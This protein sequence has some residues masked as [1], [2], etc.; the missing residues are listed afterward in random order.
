MEKLPK[1]VKRRVTLYI[2][3]RLLVIVVL[4][5]LIHQRNYNNVFT[6]ILTLV[7]FMI[8]AIADRK[9][10]IKLPTALEVVIL[11]FIFAAEILGEIQGFY[12]AFKYWDLMLHTINGFLMAAIGFAMI[13]ILN[14][15]PRIHIN[16]SPAF[17]AFVAFCFSMTIGVVWEFFEFGMDTYARTDMQKDTLCQTVS[18]VDF[19]PAGVNVPVV[20]S[21]IQ[22]TVIHGTIKGEQTEL[23]IEGGY[24][25]TGLR[26]TM[27]DMLVNLIG[28][29]VFSGLGFF[30]IKNRGKGRIVPSFIPR[31]KT[32]AEIAETEKELE[33]LR[34]KR[35]KTE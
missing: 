35:G 21:D 12:L 11:L 25:D 2:V 13:D 26:D 1:G 33:E 27:E 19:N 14:Q 17:V 31:L 20:V 18:S 6:C 16:L 22:E 9:L 3:L 5:L 28:A 23:V 4:I 34:Q 24:L 30:Y 32:K 7:L 10:N 8:P 29:V 15:N